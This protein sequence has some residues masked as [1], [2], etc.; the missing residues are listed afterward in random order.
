M[1][2]REKAK[3]ETRQK[4]LAVTKTEFINNGFL[5]LSTVNIAKQAGVAHGTVFFHFNN[6]ETLVVAVLDQELFTITTALNQQLYG[7]YDL[8]TL[9]NRYLDFLEEEEAFFTVIARETPFYPAKL[10]RTIHGREAAIR[11]YFYRAL[12]KEIKE[13]KFKDVDITLTLNMLFATLN[14]YLGLREA[15][16]S[17]ESVI[18]EKRQIIV[19]TFLKMLS[20]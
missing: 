2:L 6:K 10:R 14:Y 7:D 19:D 4:I 20:I 17:G 18:R 12:E 16:V 3:I 15:F 5:N 8:K 13:N 9:L 11:V 1:N